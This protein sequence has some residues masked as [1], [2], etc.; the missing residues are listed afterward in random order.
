MRYFSSFIIFLCLVRNFFFLSFTNSL[1]LRCFGLLCIFVFFCSLMYPRAWNSAWLI[2]GPKYLL[3]ERIK[4]LLFGSWAALV[5]ILLFYL[6]DTFGGLATIHQIS[7]HPLTLYYNRILFIVTPMLC[8]GKRERTYRLTHC[9]D[10][11]QISGCLELTLEVRTK[12]GCRG[13]V[14]ICLGEGNALKL[15]YG[16]RCTAL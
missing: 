2:V 10:R 12:S 1:E 8:G 13:A 7:I 14:G 9:R 3:N 4:G 5:C 11:K 16:N 6:P 15:G